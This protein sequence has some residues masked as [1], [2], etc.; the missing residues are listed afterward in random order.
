[1]QK[2]LK[3]LHHICHKIALTNIFIVWFTMF[4]LVAI[5]ARKT[6]DAGTSKKHVTAQPNPF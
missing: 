4:K 3:S 2:K 1:M 5:A 6:T